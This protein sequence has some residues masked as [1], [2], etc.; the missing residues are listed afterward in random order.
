MTVNE[1]LRAFIEYKDRQNKASDLEKFTIS[2]FCLSIGTSKAF[3]SS[4]R[5]SVSIDKIESIALIYPELN[6]LW[7]LL[8][9]GEMICNNQSDS[10]KEEIRILNERLL[11][12]D[13]I[14]KLLE[15]RQGLFGKTGFG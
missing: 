8:G 10:S 6:I 7:L 11:E 1:R 13:K 12:K 15:E 9:K 14:I 4:M 5:K 3:V 2:T